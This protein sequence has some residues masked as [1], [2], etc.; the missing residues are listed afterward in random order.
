MAAT[1]PAPSRT[2]ELTRLDPSTIVAE[3]AALGLM[4]GQRV[5]DDFRLYEHV[6]RTA[7]QGTF[8]LRTLTVIFNLET[9]DTFQA[10]AYH[11]GIRRW[12][13]VSVGIRGSLQARLADQRALGRQ[14]E[15]GERSPAPLP[16]WYDLTH[17][18]YGHWDELGFDPSAPVFQILPPPGSDYVNLAEALHLRQPA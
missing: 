8:V 15:P 4:E 18:A 16:D 17:I 2:C 5:P 10:H 9:Y 6:E 7:P 13:H 3:L 11:F 12:R 14:R 1:A